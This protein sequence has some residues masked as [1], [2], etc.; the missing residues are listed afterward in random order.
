[1]YKTKLYGVWS[2][3]RGRTSNTNKYSWSYKYYK[4]ISL[5]NEWKTFEGFYYWAKDKYKEGLEIDRIDNKK[6]YYPN[7]CRFVTHSENAQNT[8][9]SCQWILFGKKFN[10]TRE[11]ANY[12]NVNRG[13]IHEWCVG[14]KDINKPIKQCYR[15]FNYS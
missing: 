5:C 13:R 14:K 6:G 11:A 9:K 4:N 7:N 8:R 12:F 10:S 2:G 15:E 1:M 3:M